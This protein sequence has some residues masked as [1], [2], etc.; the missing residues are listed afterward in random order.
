MASTPALTPRPGQPP[1]SPESRPA[2]PTR[3]W[4]AERHAAIRRLTEHY[5]HTAHAAD[6]LLYPARHPVTVAPPAPGMHP[7][8]LTSHAQ[9]L[10]W[11]DAE[12]H[13]LLATVNHAASNRLE[14]CA[15]QLAW[16]MET[17]H[18]RRG[19]WHDWTAT[20]HTALAAASRLGDTQGQACAHR[21]AEAAE[22]YR[23][24]TKSRTI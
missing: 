20:Q 7:E 22:C 6:L 9:A 21:G 15:W 12:R 4:P 16:A 1:A 11:F 3:H 5:L 18:Y 19:H 2:K 23:R 14:P 24:A 10:A 8:P 13:V 17:F